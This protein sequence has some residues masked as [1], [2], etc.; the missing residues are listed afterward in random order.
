M[1]CYSNLN[2]DEDVNRCIKLSNTIREFIQKQEIIFAQC[3]ILNEV[4]T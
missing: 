1:I 3:S 4:I 2:D